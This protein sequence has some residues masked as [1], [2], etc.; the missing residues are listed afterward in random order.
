M[1]GDT[2][3]RRGQRPARTMV[4]RATAPIRSPFSLDAPA[5]AFAARLKRKFAAE[6]ARDPRAFKKAVLHYLRIHLPPGPGRLPDEAIT[7]ATTLRSMGRQWK[8]IYPVCIPAYDK[9]N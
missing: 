6:I 3:K 2:A 9:L 4:R 1:P 7:R 5:A 8:D